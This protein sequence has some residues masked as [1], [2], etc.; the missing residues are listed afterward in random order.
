[1]IKKIQ[2]NKDNVS[3]FYRKIRFYRFLKLFGYSFELKCDNAIE[4]K[5]ELNNIVKILN[6]KGRR[7]TYSLVYDYSCDVLD[8]E[9][10]CNNLCDFKNNTC[11]SNRVKQSKTRSCCEERNKG[12]CKH[13][14]KKEKRCSI[15]SIS[16]KLFVCPYLIK[17]GN[18]YGVNRVVYL[19][20]FLSIRQKCICYVSFFED[21]EQVINKFMK[22]Y[23]WY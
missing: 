1:M 13:F 7:N 10:A 20:Y 18:K 16:C 22:I 6:T 8:N 12:I 17:K 3:T 21:K 15:K 23:K 4:K 14:N 5:D 9:F 19:K 11:I 2:I